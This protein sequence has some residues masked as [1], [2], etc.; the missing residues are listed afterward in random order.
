MRISVLS[1]VHANL[2]ALEAVLAHAAA[3]NALDEVWALGDLVGYGAQPSACLALLREHPLRAV[4]GNHDLAAIGAI[5]IEAF[6]PTAAAAN[7]WTAQQLSEEDR[8]FLGGLERTIIDAPF[9]LA[10]GSLRDPV[11]EYVITTIAALHQFAAMTTAY[12]FVGHTHVPL[13]ISEQG[14]RDATLGPVIEPG[15]G[16]VVALDKARLILNPG[17]VGQPR[18][19]DPRAAYAVYDRDSARVQFHRVEYDIARTQREIAAAGLPQSLVTR[20]AVGR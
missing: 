5:G 11:W 15:A 1:D 8:A 12:S 13:V 10:H 7:R 19:G 9:S 20:L 18:D 17:S 4:A 14:G 2:A 16:E 3:E 6:N